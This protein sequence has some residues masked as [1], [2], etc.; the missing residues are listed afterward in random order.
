MSIINL[1][2]SALYTGGSIGYLILNILKMDKVINPWSNLITSIILVVISLIFLILTI[3][4]KNEGK[5]FIIINSIVLVLVTISLLIELNVFKLPQK[6]IIGNLNNKP[7]TEVMKMGKDNNITINYSTEYS[8]N[9]PTN[10]VISQDIDPNTLLSQIKTINL[11]VSSGP[12]YDKDVVIPNMIGWTSDKVL[13][14]I[15]KNHLNNVNVNF[16]TSEYDKNTVIEQSL[17]GNAK[18]NSSISLTLSY[19][20][21]EPSETTLIDL[22]N[23]NRFEIEFYL[24]MNALNYGF[25]YEFSD[26]IQKNNI[27]SYNYKEND[28]V[29]KDN[30]IE[31][32]LSKGKSITIPNL[33]QMSTDEINEFIINNNLKVS[34]DDKYDDKTE[35]GKV[36][37]VNYKENDIVEEGSLITIVLSKG[38]LKMEQFNNLSEFKDWANKY[39]I[40]YNE[41]Y[42][43]NDASNGSIIGFSKSIGEV[44]GNNETITVNISKGPSISIP[45]F[46]GMNKSDITKKCNSIGLTCKFNYSGYSQTAYD[47]AVSQSKTG[48]E[49]S[50]GTTVTINLSKGPA[51]S[52][53]L[54]LQSNWFTG[55]S[56][57][58][59]I[60][61]LTNNLSKNYPD[62][63]FKYV[64][65]PSNSGPS[66]GFHENSPTQTGTTVVQGKTY[67][68]WIKQ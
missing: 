43:F 29:T 4:K 26:N 46:V 30:K 47:V 65:K 39:G 35:L 58:A 42:Q 61:A 21:N 17:K 24:K 40:K 34:Y 48:G 49:V 44:I 14:Y 5:I 62:V 16:I 67:E 50:R 56:T 52:F 10:Y 45:S 15:N 33:Y 23:K 37:S 6:Q 1:I 19:G 7:I 55:G 51:K 8:D 11:I 9:I 18:R 31:V 66:G 60:S 41:N 12:N 54:Y 27:I 59:T 36:V 20:L 28:V 22:S 3:I 32:I 53:T 2:I 25:L 64:V 13:E 63:H 57:S 38:Q 68:I